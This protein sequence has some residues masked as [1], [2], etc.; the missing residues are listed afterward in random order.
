MYSAAL[1]SA[2]GFNELGSRFEGVRQ[3]LGVA[4]STSS[5][6]QDSI[7][8]PLSDIGGYKRWTSI[9]TGLQKWT[10]EPDNIRLRIQE[11][12]R[13]NEGTIHKGRSFRAAATTYHCWMIGHDVHC[14]RPTVVISH[15]AQPILKRTMR[16]IYRHG[17]L[18]N[19]GFG[20]TGCP[21]CDL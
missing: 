4:K 15:N 20:L 11:L 1:T 10:D 7:G 9:G 2:F 16:I 12:I 8:V 17:I 13:E 18:R 6:Y 21:S 5:T 3:A 14:V 19:Y